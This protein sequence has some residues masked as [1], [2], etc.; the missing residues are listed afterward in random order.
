MAK[1]KEQKKIKA[2]ETIEGIFRTVGSFLDILSD[3]VQKGDIQI[4]RK[5]ETEFGERKGMKAAAVYGFS[6][7][8]GDPQGGT[9]PFLEVR[10][11]EDKGI[12]TEEVHEMEDGFFDE[13]ETVVV[14]TE[15]PGTSGKDITV[16]VRR[17][18]NNHC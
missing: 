8:L 9:Q 16:E 13:K 5:G 11:L 1:G 3:M 10:S 18:P 12:R 2:E 7:N 6:V 4:R 17:Y 15:L 14:V